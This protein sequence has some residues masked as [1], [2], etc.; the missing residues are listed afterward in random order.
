MD[1]FSKQIYVFQ[2]KG[3]KIF[4]RENL[5]YHKHGGWH[6]YIT[7]DR[8]TSYTLKPYMVS[9]SNENEARKN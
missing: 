2:S 6:E 5:D 9:K 4:L 3:K 1:N 7:L 8:F